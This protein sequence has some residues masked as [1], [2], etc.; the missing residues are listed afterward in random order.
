MPKLT[1]GEFS[2]LPRFLFTTDEK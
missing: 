1:V 2:E